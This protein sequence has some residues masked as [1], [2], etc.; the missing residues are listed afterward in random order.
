[1][2]SG[3]VVALAVSASPT[4]AQAAT[5]FS[6]VTKTYDVGTPGVN[7]GLGRVDLSWSASSVGGVTFRVEVSKDGGSYGLIDSTGHGQGY[8]NVSSSGHYCYRIR[9]SS[10]V[11]T[12]PW[13]SAECVSVGSHGAGAPP[14]PQKTAATSL[15]QVFEVYEVGEPLNGGRGRLGFTWNYDYSSHSYEIQGRKNTSSTYVGIDHSGFGEGYDDVA[16]AGTYCYRIRAKQ[17][18]LDWSD[19]SGERCGTVGTYVASTPKHPTPSFTS[20]AKRFD[21]GD[22]LG[23]NGRGRVDFVWPYAGGVTYEIQGRKNTSP[24]HSSVD[25]SGFGEGFDNVTSAGTY[26]YRIRATRSGYTWSNWSTDQCT[27]VGTYVA[28]KTPTPSFTSVSKVYDVGN[29]AVNDGLGRVNVFWPYQSGVTYEVESRRD[30]DVWWSYFTD[31]DHIG[32]GA[33]HDNVTVAD[34]HCYRIRATESGHSP[35]DWSAPECITVDQ[36]AAPVIPQHPTPSFSSVSKVYDVGNPSVNSGRGRV[37]VFWPYQSGVTYDIESRRISTSA[38][39]ISTYAN[40][41]HIGF[42]EGFDSISTAGQHCYRIRATRS[43]YTWSDWSA[44]ECVAVDQAELP[45]L[46]T[47]SIGSIETVAN[48]IGDADGQLAINITQHATPGVTY[49]LERQVGLGWQLVDASASLTE[50]FFGPSSLHCFRVRV[51]KPGYEDSEWSARKCW[52][53]PRSLAAPS[54]SSAT[55][56]YDAGS[57]AVNGG[58]GRVN[59]TWSAP[60][61]SGVSFEVEV[62]Q[63]DSPHYGRVQNLGVGQVGHD[64]I[65]ADRYCYRLR[66]RATS[67]AWSPWSGDRCVTVGDATPTLATPSISTVDKISDAVGNGNGRLDVRLTPHA[68]HGVTYRLEYRRLSLIH[69]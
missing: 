39:S 50:N 44:D 42:G 24:S 8:D 35:S 32:P 6:S 68:T 29:D 23:S 66:V 52:A 28:P 4:S 41:D 64:V 11:G 45:K 10:I 53:F 12:G 30:I 65:A 2:L 20:V 22:P 9:W 56:V 49:R 67:L 19:W 38:Y 21:V 46:S 14:A 55:K 5:S 47:P 61:V 62:K 48:Q 33:G 17:V 34:Q 59:L 58:R 1:M 54:F 26:C 18:G 13:S 63:G 25:H 51:S 57:P 15:T 16:I 40:V 43:G 37:N 27:S 7:G 36:Y 60:S 3:V 69:I 31:I